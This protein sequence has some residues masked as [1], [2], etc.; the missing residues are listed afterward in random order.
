MPVAGRKVD[1]HRKFQFKLYTMSSDNGFDPLPHD[2][3]VGFTEIGGLRG[4]TEVVT[5]KEGNDNFE[6]KVPGRTTYGSI[7]CSRGID[8]HGNLRAWRHKVVEGAGF[9]DPIRATLVIQLL[10]RDGSVVEREWEA[11]AAWPST[12]EMDDLSGSASDVLVES[13]EFAVEEI[14]LRKTT[15]TAG[16]V[17][18][19]WI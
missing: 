10:A 7:R 6:R 3:G 14:R 5:Y 13:V 18:R 8:A 15:D 11:L 2:S 12:Y 1:P 17:N 16:P 4:E 19:A 9:T